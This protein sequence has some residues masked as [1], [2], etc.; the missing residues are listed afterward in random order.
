[1]DVV[2]IARARRVAVVGGIAVLVAKALVGLARVGAFIK[3]WAECERPGKVVDRTGVSRDAGATCGCEFTD[4][5]FAG[6][7][8]LIGVGVTG[9]GHTDLAL[10]G[11]ADHSAACFAR[12]T[13]CGED[14]TNEQRDHRD[15]HK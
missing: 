11:K 1:M 3:E 14:E 10:V 9:E 4:A 7:P 5:R 12:F 2:R 6:D 8:F 13:Q 15:D